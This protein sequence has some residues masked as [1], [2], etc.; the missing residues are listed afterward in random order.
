MPVPLSSDFTVKNLEWDASLGASYPR[1]TQLQHYGP[2]KGHLLATYA[3]RGALPIYRSTDNGDTFQFFSEIKGLRGQPALY[4]LPVK[5]GEFPA[6]AIMAAAGEE[7]TDP[8]KRS[9]GCYHSSDGGK[10]WHY[11][12]TYAVG[13]PGRYDPNDRAGISLQQNPVFEPYL[14][15]DSK[16]RL[17]VCFSDERFKKDGYSQ[18][19][20]HRVSED[21][22]RTWGEL[23]YDVAIA[24]GREILQMVPVNGRIQYSKFLLPETTKLPTYPFPWDK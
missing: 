20:V 10:T 1:V 14:Y 22:G 17:V 4:E 11:L 16:G 18:L 6:G 19:L 9:L 23:V 8:N 12:S 21:G 15:A 7:S 24:D 5:M 3:R 13:G 2:G